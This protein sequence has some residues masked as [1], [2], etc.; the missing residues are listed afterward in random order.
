MKGF[1]SCRLDS[2]VVW[3]AG[4]FHF[5]NFH[6]WKRLFR[7]KSAIEREEKLN[8]DICWFLCRRLIQRHTV[9]WRHKLLA[10]TRCQHTA[11]YSCTEYKTWLEK[12]RQK[13]VVPVVLCCCSEVKTEKRKH[14]G[15]QYFRRCI[16]HTYFR[17]ADFEVAKTRILTCVTLVGCCANLSRWTLGSCTSWNTSRGACT[18]WR[19]QRIG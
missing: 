1:P 6:N 8:L 2:T 11:H 12:T 9:R 14:C 7:D 16:C 5:V 17:L 15:S 10:D 19:K 13:R 4:N 3:N 18:S